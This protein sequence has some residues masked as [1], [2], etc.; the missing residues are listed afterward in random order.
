MN[1]SF[2]EMS[3]LLKSQGIKNHDF[4]LKTVNPE[5]EGVD[6]H[7]P[8]LTY[9]QIEAVVVECSQ[10]MWYF[11]RE[12][13]RIPENL[14]RQDTPIIPMKI[15]QSTLAMLYCF[16]REIDTWVTHSRGTYHTWTSLMA[17]LWA[18][19]FKGSPVSLWNGSHSPVVRAIRNNLPQYMRFDRMIGPD[20]S[21][22]HHDRG[23]SFNYLSIRSAEKAVHE[24][25]YPSGTVQLVGD[26]EFLTFLPE[27]LDANPQL[28]RAKKDG[29]HHAQIFDSSINLKLAYDRP[30]ILIFINSMPKWNSIYYDSNEYLHLSMLN[31]LQRVH[32]Q[33]DFLELG[34]GGD[35]F[36][37][38]AMTMFN[39]DDKIKGELLLQRN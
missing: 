15:H 23:G 9:S 31:Q 14:A 27:Y 35:W 18:A 26:A 6:P 37:K 33:F 11:L 34:F 8:N 17:A 24:A 21:L 22:V 20:G 3:N 32:I 29:F 36:D 38:M 28:H 2:V 16:E 39:R 4:M 30:E 25:K 5:L 13:V 19:I 12:C 1:H 10:N 7:D